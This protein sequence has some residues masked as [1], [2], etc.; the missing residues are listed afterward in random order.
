MEHTRGIDGFLSPKQE[1]EEKKE[2]EQEIEIEQEQEGENKNSLTTLID[3]TSNESL[4]RHLT[5]GYI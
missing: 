4:S 1:K 2:Q 3:I 5:A